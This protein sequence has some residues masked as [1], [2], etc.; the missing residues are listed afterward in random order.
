MWRSWERAYVAK[1]VHEETYGAEMSI[2]CV[3]DNMEI[4]EMMDLCW[5]N[6]SVEDKEDN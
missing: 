4:P 2:A 1:R 6:D 5:V 3:G